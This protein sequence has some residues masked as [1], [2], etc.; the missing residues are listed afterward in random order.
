M[1]EPR[2]CF[3][4]LHNQRLGLLTLVESVA[5]AELTAAVAAFK[6]KQAV[7]KSIAAAESEG[8]R[9]NL[10]TASLK[11]LPAAS[12]AALICVFCNRGGDEAG[13]STVTTALA[14]S[15]CQETSNTSGWE[16]PGAT[17]MP[18]PFS[19]K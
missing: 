6:S 19:A 3:R 16:K 1:L 17:W 12:T 13:P 15:A 18:S 10:K 5:A 9:T 2:D 8:A 7:T 14:R 4:K 11:S